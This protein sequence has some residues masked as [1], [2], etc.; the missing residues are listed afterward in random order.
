M[1]FYKL[2][3]AL[4]SCFLITLT[5]RNVVAPP[6]LAVELLSLKE[7][8]LT[9]KIPKQQT[10]SVS[11]EFT[12][13][14]DSS[15]RRYLDQDQ[16]D[17]GDEFK[18]SDK[19]PE[20]NDWYQEHDKHGN[21]GKSPQDVDRHTELENQALVEKP[22]EFHNNGLL[23]D[24][25]GP[26]DLDNPEEGVYVVSDYES[27]SL[28]TNFSQYDRNGDGYIDLEELKIATQYQEN[29]V[30]ALRVSD[31]DGKYSETSLNRP[32][33]GQEFL[34]GLERVRFG[35]VTQNPDICPIPFRA[36]HSPCAVISFEK[37]RL[38]EVPLFWL[39]EFPC[40]KLALDK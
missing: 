3:C 25:N 36:L 22:K 38:R 23:L 34:I 33:S 2:G 4:V 10:D 7:G 27:L 17:L 29:A 37:D 30:L 16:F 8:G 5:I 39:S 24:V 35:E 18:F 31:I 32:P 1:A 26:M 19:T 15:V 9:E 21:F 20:E 28:P 13:D 14:S 6:P 12:I 40:Q 11:D